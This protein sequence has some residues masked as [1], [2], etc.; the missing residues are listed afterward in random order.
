MLFPSGSPPPPYFLT[1][2]LAILAKSDEKP[3]RIQIV[4]AQ[5]CIH[6]LEVLRSFD[7]L[8]RKR[9]CLYLWQVVCASE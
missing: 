3:L 2:I 9:A 7:D 4:L 8:N 1:N 5:S 6:I